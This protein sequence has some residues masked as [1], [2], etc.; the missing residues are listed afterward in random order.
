M[1]RCGTAPN[2]HVI[3]PEPRSIKRYNIA[4]DRKQIERPNAY[5][6]VSMAGSLVRSGKHREVCQ[7]LFIVFWK[8]ANIMP[9]PMSE[10]LLKRVLV[11]CKNELISDSTKNFTISQYEAN[12]F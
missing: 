9:V 7:T 4:K 8:F 2:K 11:H 6:S 5:G 10:I 3:R 1:G 12:A